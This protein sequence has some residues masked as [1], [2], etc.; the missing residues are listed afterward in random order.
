MITSL[1][2]VVRSAQAYRTTVDRIFSDPLAEPEAAQ[3]YF[4]D[5]LIAVC[6]L[7]LDYLLVIKDQTEIE[8]SASLADH[9]FKRIPSDT[10]RQMELRE[11]LRKRLETLPCWE[12][13]EPFD[14]FGDYT[15]LR[16]LKDYIA[17]FVGELPDAYEETFRVEQ[18]AKG[19]LDGA[20]CP[21]EP[22][23]VALEHMG[24]NHLTFVRY[25]LEG[26]ANSSNWRIPEEVEG[27]ADSPEPLP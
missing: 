24:R 7:Y 19:L 26:A 10:D 15:G 2:N 16:T 5:L 12:Y 22:L 13:F 8:R 14:A 17:R 11:R 23:I 1:A 4:F 21:V 6:Q 9:G 18:Y 27:E 3:E 20:G 25:A